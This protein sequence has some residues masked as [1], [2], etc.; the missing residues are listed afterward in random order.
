MQLLVLLV[1][2]EVVVL[3]VLVV[4]CRWVVMHR[5]GGLVRLLFGE[6]SR[7]GPVA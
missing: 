4:G 2:D 6:R 1:L 5:C 3:V 7:Y